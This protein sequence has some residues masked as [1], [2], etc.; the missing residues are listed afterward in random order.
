MICPVCLYIT[1]SRLSRCF[2]N[3]NFVLN[4]MLM[5]Y[6]IPLWVGRDCPS[7]LQLVSVVHYE[8]GQENEIKLF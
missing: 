5:D 4:A 2:H 6:A 8:W 3:L 1:K 7:H